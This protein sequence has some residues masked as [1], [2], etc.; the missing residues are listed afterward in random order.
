MN[1]EIQGLFNTE[2]VKLIDKRYRYL[3][4]RRRKIINSQLRLLR[5]LRKKI[6]SIYTKG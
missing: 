5:Y 1:K 6:A 2:E 4:E 3:D